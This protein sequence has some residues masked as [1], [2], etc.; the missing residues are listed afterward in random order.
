ML[1]DEQL[2]PF[3][4]ADIERMAPRRARARLGRGG[5]AAGAVERAQAAVRRRQRWRHGA[6]RRRRW[7]ATTASSI[8]ALVAFVREHDVVT[9]PEWLGTMEIV[10]TPA[11]PAA[12]FARRV[13]EPAAPLFR[14]DHR[15]L[16]H[17]SADVARRSRRA[18]RHERGLR[19]R[20]HPLDCRA[21][22]DAR[23]FPAVLDRPSAFRLRAQDQERRR[24]QRRLG[25][26]RR[27]DVRPPRPLRRRPRCAPLHR[28][29]GARARRARHRRR[30]AR[31]RRV[32][33]RAGDRVLRRP[34]GIHQA[35]PRR[36]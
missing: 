8:A 9:V 11:L 17:H 3:D 15:P 25:F 36:R 20:S 26:L 30:P 12:G 10:E 31:D 13:D 24:V 34:V 7:S 5:V 33:D 6:E 14:V 4:G 21:R 29:L 27:G 16:L 18:A 23:P 2:L 28:P 1:R 35:A 19:S 32:D 22:G